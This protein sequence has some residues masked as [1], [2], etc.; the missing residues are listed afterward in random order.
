MAA[1]SLK[2]RSFP[3]SFAM[4]KQ[5]RK[6]CRRRKF[7]PFVPWPNDLSKMSHVLSKSTSPFPSPHESMA[8]NQSQTVAFRFVWHWLET[9]TA[10]WLAL[11]VVTRRLARLCLCF[12]R[13][14]RNWPAYACSHRKAHRHYPQRPV[15][16]LPITATPNPSINTDAAPMGV[17]SFVIT[18]SPC[19]RFMFFGRSAGYVKRWASSAFPRYNFRW[20]PLE[21]NHEFQYRVRGR[22]G[23]PLAR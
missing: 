20:L 5:R 15:V 3:A 9:Q 2:F 14:R 4:A 18:Q 23:W 19:L 12:S 10:I 13:R 6:P 16:R 7:L 11:H 8:V 21:M 17:F 22:N 1:G